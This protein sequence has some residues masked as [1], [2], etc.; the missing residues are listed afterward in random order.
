MATL[1]GGD[2]PLLV[3]VV[4]ATGSGKTALSL[5]LA[6]RLHGEV[7]SCDSVAVYLG[8]D[9]GSAKPT[10]A[11]R[12]RV[13]HH[14]IDVVT[15]AVEFTAGDYARTAR[16]VVQEI[17]ARGKV[18]IVAGGT[19]LYLRAFL[20]GLSAVPARDNGVRERLRRF[21]ERRGECALYRLLRRL[22]PEA[23]A[24]IH[25]NDAPKLIRAIEVSLL[26]RR[27]MSKAF[28]LERPEPL[29]GFRVVQVGLL[30]ERELLYR[31]IDAR[32]E[33]MF[34]EG[35]V[36]ETRGLVDLYGP[37]CRAFTALGYSQ[38]L[39]LLG[40]QTTRTEAVRLTQQGHRNYAKRQG[41]WFRRDKRIEWL[42]GFGESRAG[43]VME[44]IAAA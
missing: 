3:V 44:R 38:A 43:A 40:G 26:A 9:V 16:T 19:G 41:T 27:P 36:E 14:L 4:G 37:D 7:V 35:L 25:A 39:A 31:R 13:R 32:C 23:A 5:E 17:A 1:V 11:E 42:H 8:M 15:P 34:A 12:D 22:D 10:R 29:T 30:P 24:R 2:D 18:P 33:R 20:D 6:E 21:A 28:A